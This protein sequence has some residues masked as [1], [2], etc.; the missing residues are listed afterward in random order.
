MLLCLD[1]LSKREALHAVLA[2][3]SVLG[4]RFIENAHIHVVLLPH[5]TGLSQAGQAMLDA[6][7]RRE[8]CEKK[9]ETRTIFIGKTRT[10]TDCILLAFCII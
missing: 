6:L 5:V 3:S 1:A 2:L 10:T 7:K 4:T 8:F 9:K